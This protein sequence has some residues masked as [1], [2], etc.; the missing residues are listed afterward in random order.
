[1]ALMRDDGIEVNCGKF[2]DLLAGVKT[3]TGEKPF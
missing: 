3:V 1:M 2:G